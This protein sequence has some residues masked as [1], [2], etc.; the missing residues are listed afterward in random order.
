M[1]ET[2]RVLI[3]EDADVDSILLELSNEGV[4]EVVRSRGHP[5][6]FA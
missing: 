4:A 3:V 5:L 1:L 6:L 2:L